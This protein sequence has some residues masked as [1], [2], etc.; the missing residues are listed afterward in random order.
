MKIRT[1]SFSKNGDK[2]NRTLYEK[3]SGSEEIFMRLNS[4]KTESLS[5]WTEKAF[6][7]SDALIFIGAAGI[8]VRAISPFV[9]RKDKDPAVIVC[10]ELG[11]FVIPILSGHIGGAN[12]LAQRIAGI[13][14]ATP[15]ITT[16]TDIN[17]VWAVDTWAVK[18]GYT[19]ENPE[20]IKYI[21]SALLR[22]EKVGIVSDVHKNVNE[23]FGNDGV[24]ENLEYRN[25]ELEAGISISPYLTDVWF[26]TLHVIPKCLIAGVG[27]RKEADKENADAL[28]R[29]ILKKEKLS[30]KAISDI[31][32]I[33]IK[34]DE[35]AITELSKKLIVPLKTYS[36]EELNDLPEKFRFEESDFV[37]NITGTGNVC[38]RS[39]VKK[40]LEYADADRIKIVVPK[41]KGDSV[42][43]AVIQYR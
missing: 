42:T 8:A 20:V 10:D 4:E 39:A 30:I 26:H 36:A 37:K 35:P 17:N 15:V 13:L 25:T 11:H 19:I 40:A 43:A 23:I 9:K 21:S 2:L 22:G 6:H 28:L 24:P 14:G 33:D 16:A 38:E 27:S 18:Q 31:A 32:T 29:D 12:E 7:D 3:L 41:T 1:V 5:E 34:K